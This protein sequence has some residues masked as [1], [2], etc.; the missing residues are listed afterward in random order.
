MSHNLLEPDAI[1]SSDAMRWI[2]D[3]KSLRKGA[4]S[5][6][7]ILAAVAANG[8]FTIDGVIR[9]HPVHLD[10]LVNAL[11]RSISGAMHRVDRY[12]SDRARSVAR[13]SRRWSHD[14]KASILRGLRTCS[15]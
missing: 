12:P 15:A 2:G 11:M 4:A 6:G 1:N 10:R 3:G 14:D 7:A 8:G 5:L 9:R 13:A